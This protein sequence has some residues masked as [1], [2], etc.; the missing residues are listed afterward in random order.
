M[1][2]APRSTHIRGAARLTAA[3]VLA[4]A[5]VATAA[6]AAFRGV[7]ARARAAFAE[8]RRTAPA[9]QPAVGDVV[10]SVAVAD[11]VVIR[12]EFDVTADGLTGVRLRTV[13]WGKS[14]EDYDCGW[15]LVEVAAD[16]RSL[17]TV[18]SG[19]ISTASS[20]D[21]GYAELLFEPIIDSAAARYALR[22]TTGPGSR[23]KPLGLP[24]FRP[25]EPAVDVSVRQ[26]RGG[27]RRDLP[28]PAVLDV[29]LVHV[30][31]GG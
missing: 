15:S 22:I 27:P 19:T 8:H 23:A 30:S 25:V 1:A 9:A 11:D 4:L 5:L 10:G 7:D 6:T 28:L 24:L 16:G 20:T 3:W 13:T 21:W 14:P 17:R 18:R 12:H 2:I 26:R 31:E 29:Q